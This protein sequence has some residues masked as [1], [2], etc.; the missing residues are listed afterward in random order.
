[1]VNYATNQEL[2]DRFEDVAS[3]ASATDSTDETT[4]D[5]DVLTNAIEYAEGLINSY[6]GKRYLTPVNVSSDTQLENLLRG[7]TL[8][9]AVFELVGTRNDLLSEAK[10]RA[11]DRC[12]EW[13]EMLAKGDVVLTG[14][15]TI[16]TTAARDPIAQ[17]GS[18]DHDEDSGTNTRD[19]T[20]ARVFSRTTMSG[21]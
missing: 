15:S 4:P 3:A 8:D 11:Y 21:L 19:F 16:P 13:L 14:A 2:I 7:R 12:I 10:Q 18:A 17:W 6:I 5:A 20:A 1:M 9:V